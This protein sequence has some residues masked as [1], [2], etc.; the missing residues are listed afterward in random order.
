MN[1]EYIIADHIRAIVFIISEGIL[2]SGKG[3]GYV[4]RRLM[5]RLISASLKLNI[6]I[7][8]SNYFNDLVDSVIAKYSNIYPEI[9]GTRL[10]T[11][12]ILSNEFKKYQRAIEIGKKEWAKILN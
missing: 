11:L 3:R 5:R 7:E 8:N 6:T 4:L 1:P 2:P 9:I 12:E 10:N